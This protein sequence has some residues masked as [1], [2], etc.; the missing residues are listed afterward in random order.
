M[1]QG[2][3]GIKFGDHVAVTSDSPNEKLPSP[4]ASNISKSVLLLAKTWLRLSNA[5][6]LGTLAA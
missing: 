2:A 3:P 6:L 1:F 4:L 5:L